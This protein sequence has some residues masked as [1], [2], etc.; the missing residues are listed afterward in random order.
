MIT[1]V[2]SKSSNSSGFSPVL[3]KFYKMIC[4]ITVSKTVCGIFLIFCRPSFMNNFMVKNNFLEAKN[5]RNLNISRPTYLKK[6]IPQRFVVLICTKKIFFQ[7]VG[8]FFT[9][10]N[11]LIWASFFSTKNWFHAFFQGWLFNFNIIVKTCFKNLFR[12]TVKKR[13]FYFFK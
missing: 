13:W 8:A 10:A 9:T 6:K 2:L 7:G 11:P 5:H 4:E 12:K 1:S 3:Q